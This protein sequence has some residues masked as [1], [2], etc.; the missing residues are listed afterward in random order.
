MRLQES[1]G[2]VVT[3]E[4]TVQTRRDEL[5]T[6]GD[7]NAE[8]KWVLF[9]VIQTF[10]TPEFTTQD[11]LGTVLKN[12]LM[13]YHRQTIG[14]RFD[15]ISSKWGYHI[16]P[17]Q[18]HDDRGYLVPA[19]SALDQVVSVPIEARTPEK[20]LDA[21]AVAIG[22]SGGGKI[23][24]SAVAGRAHGFNPAF[25]AL[26]E[27]FPWGVDSVLARD[28]LIDLLGR[29]ATTFGWHLMCQPSLKATDRLCVLNLAAMSVPK[30]DFQ[31]NPVINSLG[32][33][34]MRVLWYDRC[35]DCPPVDQIKA[36]GRPTTTFRLTK[37]TS[38]ACAHT[39][40]DSRRLFSKMSRSRPLAS[41]QKVV[42][43]YICSVYFTNEQIRRT[44][45]TAM[46]LL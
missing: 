5:Q 40:P 35:K 29:S 17:V 39:L 34:E 4:E 28:A 19:M 10:V 32:N 38:D 11:D 18:V 12:T 44:G 24:T 41:I 1:Y 37:I 22:E 26:P 42:I 25:R 45:R 14:T 16:V 23:I 15:M 27:V 2:S 20:H 36:S 6:K 46:L 7:R 21:L 9:P 43:P 3:Y 13:A 31:G 33:A 8:N 30:T